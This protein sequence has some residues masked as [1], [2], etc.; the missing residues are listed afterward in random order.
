MSIIKDLTELVSAQVISNDTAQQIS[1]YYRS[2]GAKPDNSNRQLLIFGVFG[3]LLVGVGLMFIVANQWEV[4]PVIVK[5]FCAFLLL[6]IPQLL[7]G[8]VLLKKADKIVWRESTALMLF[9]AVGANISLVSQIYHING[10]ASSFLLVWMLLTLPL[11]YILD[12]SAISL[13]YFIGIM[14]YS[15]AV[16]SD[17]SDPLR[18]YFYWFLFVLPLPRY[19][20]LFKRSPESPLFILH[21]WIIPLVLTMILGMLSRKNAIWMYPAYVSMFG[22]IYLAGNNPF[23]SKRSILQNGYRIIGFAGMF[24]TMLILSFKMNWRDLSGRNIEFGNL[25]GTP[26]FIVNLVLIGFASMLLFRQ[27]KNLPLKKWK[28]IEA[29]YLIFMFIFILGIFTSRSYI[30]VNIYLFLM[31]MIM[32][33]KGSQLANLGELNTGLIIIALLVAFRSVDADLTFVVKGSVLVLV[34]IGFFIAN[35]LIINKRKENES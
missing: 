35:W 19:F 28:M 30:L 6:I 25:A 18:E 33:R 22:M 3:A 1:D 27:N 9:F 32:I 7:C 4:F 2:K 21:H 15:I 17:V 11:I 29:T 8:Y 34:G 5:T 12:A 20:R 24:C 26:E 10:D 31:G 23:F 16:R 14:S 13:A